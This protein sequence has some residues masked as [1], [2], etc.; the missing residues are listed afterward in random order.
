LFD[1]KSFRKYQRD[2]ASKKQLS[3]IMWKPRELWTSSFMMSYLPI[4][5]D[6]KTKML[7]YWFS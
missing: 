4:V 6:S 3:S 2:K 7:F 5:I 1:T